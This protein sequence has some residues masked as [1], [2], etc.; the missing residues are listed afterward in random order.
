MDKDIQMSSVN[1]FWQEATKCSASNF[2]Y[3]FNSSLV[4]FNESIDANVLNKLLMV[5]N[6]N[7]EAWKENQRKHVDL[8]SDL[9]NKDLQEKWEYDRTLECL[10]SSRGGKQI[11]LSHL[12]SKVFS[13]ARI[14]RSSTVHAK[15]SNDISMDRMKKTILSKYGIGRK[16]VT[17]DQRGRII[18]AEAGS[19][20]FCAGL[21]LS[22]IRHN[23][24]NPE[25]QCRRSDLC[26]LGS[27]KV[28]NDV[29]GL[30]SC[31]DVD[32]RLVF[33][34]L[35]SAHVILLTETCDNVELRIDLDVG[36]D[37]YDCET[38]YIVNVEWL[39]GSSG[40]ST[41]VATLFF[42]FSS[43]F[44]WSL[45]RRTFSLYSV[46]QV[47]NCMIFGEVHLVQL[48]TMVMSLDVNL[49]PPISLH[50]KIS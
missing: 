42:A 11:E 41:I 10:I 18:I 43:F 45:F 40:V 8:T 27:Y 5:F 3:A 39:I 47:S 7:F 35:S 21:A 6:S 48:L 28:K 33:W 14:F 26:I 32:G 29:V 1:H 31:Q 50:M 24:N 19:L 20:L 49:L 30:A 25:T 2:L 4:K 34:G 36:L 12:E 9:K 23:S 44:S 38:D 37:S 22:N 46:P 17:A 16:V 15:L 13:V